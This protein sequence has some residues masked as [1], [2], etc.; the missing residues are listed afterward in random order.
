MW[1]SKC[2]ELEL[3]SA[4]FG[5]GGTS[6]GSGKV[7]VRLLHRPSEPRASVHKSLEP[8]SCVS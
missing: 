3:L 7:D 6:A 4:K 2:G 8:A 5:R 1:R